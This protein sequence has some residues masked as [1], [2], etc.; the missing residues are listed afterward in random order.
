MLTVALFFFLFFFSFFVADFFFVFDVI[1]PRQFFLRVRVTGAACFLG[2]SLPSADDAGHAL[3][4]APHLTC[5]SG[6]VHLHLHLHLHLNYT[7]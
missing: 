6:D 3:S 4:L 1:S 2:S 5:F 7:A